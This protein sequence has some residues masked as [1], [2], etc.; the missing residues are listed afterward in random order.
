MET[1]QRG[2][3]D[4]TF[5]IDSDLATP[6]HTSPSPGCLSRGGEDRHHSS[7][8]PRRLSVSALDIDVIDRTTQIE[9]VSALQ[10]G[11]QTNIDVVHPREIGGRQ[12]NELILLSPASNSDMRAADLGSAQDDLAILSPPDQNLHSPPRVA[13]TSGI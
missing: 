2:E 1:K 4:S 5:S 3:R 11:W 6:N 8:R 7:R 13:R 12:W 9:R 10:K